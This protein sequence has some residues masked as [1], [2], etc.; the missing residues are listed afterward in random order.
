MAFKRQYPPLIQFLVSHLHDLTMIA[1]GKSS[2]TSPDVVC[3]AFY[4]LTNAAPMFTNPLPTN[5]RFLQ[6]LFSALPDPSSATDYNILSFCRIFDFIVQAS[7]GFV[8]LN[9]PDRST[10]FGRLIALLD[11]GPVFGLLSNLTTGIAP[12]VMAFLESVR[13]T[14][15]LMGALSGDFF[16]DGGILSLLV[17]LVTTNLPSELLLK[18]LADQSTL[19]R[20]SNLLMTSSDQAIAAH[21]ATLLRAMSELDLQ[22]CRAANRWLSDRLP[23]FC[24]FVSTGAVYTRSRSTIV[25]L[26]IRLVKAMMATPE[27]VLA[28]TERLFSAVFVSWGHTV[29]HQD[30]LALVTAVGLTGDLV[31]RCRMGERVA[32]ALQRYHT[33][34]AVYWGCLWT[35]VRMVRKAQITVDAW[36]DGVDARIAVADGIIAAQYGGSIK[37][38]KTG[39]AGQSD[40]DGEYSYEE[41]EEYDG[42]E[43]E[44]SD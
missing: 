39:N 42:Y 34:T 1:I 43:E 9:I 12:P 21:A 44:Y 16:L 19:E 13:A 15:A 32:E 14:T 37:D 29:L 38:A 6:D 31:A 17:N 8:F 40:S 24:E 20:L 7:N 33:D 23:S 18:P 30:F 3:A 27:C 28:M 11:R 26:I 2:C 5:R 22:C 41:E 35:L 36:A 4:C 10:L 25:S